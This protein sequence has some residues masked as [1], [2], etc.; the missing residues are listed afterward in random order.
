MKTNIFI[1]SFLLVIIVSSCTTQKSSITPKPSEKEKQEKSTRDFCTVFYEDFNNNNM[2][3]ADKQ[4]DKVYLSIENGK[5]IF[6]YK[7]KKG[8]WSVLVPRKIEL[9]QEDD[10]I[11]ETAIKQ[12]KS[13]DDKLIGLKWGHKD[14]KNEFMFCFNKEGR[15]TIYKKEDGN[16]EI[17]YTEVNSD[18]LNTSEDSKNK[19]KIRKNENKL[20]FYIN[21]HFLTDIPF[22][23]LFGNGIGFCVFGNQKIAVDYLKV[24]SPES[25][26]AFFARGRFLLV[27]GKYTKAINLF[28][29][30]IEIDD[31]ILKY[32]FWRGVSKY[33]KGEYKE[34]IMDFSSAINIDSQSEHAYY[35]RGI[36]EYR[37]GEYKKAIEDFSSAIAIAPQF[38]NA[39]YNRGKIKSII[40]GEHLASKDMKKYLELSEQNYYHPFAYYYMGKI[41][42]A[43]EIINSRIANEPDKEFHYYHR[44]CLYSINGNKEKALKNL[45]LAVD[46][47]YDDFN[48]IKEDPDLDNIKLTEEFVTILRKHGE[49]YMPEPYE[50]IQNYVKKHLGIWQ[51]KGRYE[52]TK[53]YKK[54]VNQ[55]NWQAKKNELRNRAIQ[56]YKEFYTKLI[57]WE[58]T[59]I[60]GYD[61][62]AETFQLRHK[63]LGD[64]VVPVPNE[65]A[66]E[67]E[68]HFNQARF[69]NPGVIL[70]K[71]DIKLSHLDIYIPSVDREFTYDIKQK[72][73]Y[74][75]A[76]YQVAF[77]DLQVSMP[78]EIPSKQ[79]GKSKETIDTGQ[80]EIDQKIPEISVNRPNAIAI[81]IGNKDYQHT[82]PVKY[83]LNDAQ[84]MKKYLIKTLGYKP[85]NIF[86]IENA[87]KSNFETYFGTEEDHKG[88]LYNQLKRNQSEVFVYYSG[89][90]APALD[91]HKAY[92]VPVD[93][94]PNYLE[95]GGY[96]REVFYSNLT[97]LPAKSFT[98]VI[99]A[100]FSG[101]KVYDDMSP[102]RIKVSDP[103]QKFTNGVIISS[104]SGSQVSTWYNEKKHSLFTYFFLKAIKDGE[105]ADANNDG[106]L[107]YGE[108][109]DY[110]SHQNNGVP[111]Y[112][113]KIHGVEQIPVMR[114]GAK[115]AVFVEY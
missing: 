29:K 74:N 35:W 2:K 23:E 4:T 32:Y 44:A 38:E 11:I 107:T 33:S 24:R 89:H 113:R 49:S 34:A 10:F 37:K 104:A 109:F 27:K 61:A 14:I 55:Q 101:A 56:N 97:K 7:G 47:G 8:G 98:V 105:E 63:N 51:V 41:D 65:V 103:L 102:V 1:F 106:K 87:T 84:T 26:E 30:A 86:Y 42:K 92:F 13:Q 95:Q 18:Y 21:S 110:I 25:K 78:G 64:F 52:S 40:Y 45:E 83:A 54:R 77:N 99:D 69:K 66:P 80:A 67:F 76:E 91:D 46:K 22:M 15:V 108:L 81:I 94:E 100:C 58:K 31:R 71:K 88:K 70:S 20:Y 48:Q 36:S 62:D 43:F 75:P 79:N 9:N 90:G 17:L 112:A 115:D 68:A 50:Y 93:C 111:Y 73:D 5:Y 19:L 39:Y 57:D 16:H 3:W 60:L 96:P 28:T 114:G 12:I 85:G 6:H 82:D 59:E 53:S 72:A